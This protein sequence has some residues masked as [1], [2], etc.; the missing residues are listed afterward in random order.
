MRQLHLLALIP[1]L[2]FAASATPADAGPQRRVGVVVTLA[3]GVDDAAARSISD[4]LA[5]ALRDELRVDVISGAEVERRLPPAGLPEDCVG[6]PGCR[7]DLGRRLDADELLLLAIVEVGERVNVEATWADVAS[8][9][10]ASRPR[11]TLDRGDPGKAAFAAAAKGF[12]PHI[13]EPTDPDPK[14]IVVPTPGDPQRDTGRR[15]TT[16][17]LISAGVAVAAGIAGGVLA[18][19][20][21]GK[22]DDLESDGCNARQC[23]QG[24]IDAGRRYALGAD[25]AFA[26]ALAAGVTA[27]VLYYLS[28]PDEGAPVVAPAV[29]PDQ[30][31]VSLG[32]RF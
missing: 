27:G 4:A 22:H 24:A 11:I 31:G 21:E 17:V 2:L 12:L 26:G 25:I 6:D 29:G 32:G 1:G 16:P 13:R 7:N 20:A 3:V 10:T 5:A 9:D 30:V 23:D 28:A 19:G 8:G 18:L 15:L 14:I